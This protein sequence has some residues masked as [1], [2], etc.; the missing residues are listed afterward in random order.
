MNIVRF[1]RAELNRP[2][3]QPGWIYYSEDLDGDPEKYYMLVQTETTHGMILYCCVGISDGSSWGKLQEDVHL[4]V[5]DLVRVGYCSL[6][7]QGPALP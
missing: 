2:A 7:V 3:P 6:A 4:A 5:K 1:T